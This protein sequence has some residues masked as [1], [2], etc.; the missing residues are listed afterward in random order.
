MATTIPA[1]GSLYEATL[2]MLVDS[3]LTT[4]EVSVAT[5][6]NYHWLTALRAGRFEDPGVN[7]I[8]KIY[9]FMKSRRSKAGRKK[10]K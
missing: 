7:K 3:D 9:R 1:T 2:G 10:K 8:E 4:R 5:G 6:I